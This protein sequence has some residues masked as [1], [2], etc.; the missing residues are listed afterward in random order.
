MHSVSLLSLYS[1]CLFATWPIP[2][3]FSLFFLIHFVCS[4]HPLLKKFYLIRQRK[5]VSM[6][7]Q[8]EAGYEE[9]SCMQSGS[10]R[11]RH[12]NWGFNRINARTEALFWRA[13]HPTQTLVSRFAWGILEKGFGWASGESGSRAGSPFSNSI[14]DVCRRTQI[15]IWFPIIYYTEKRGPGL[16]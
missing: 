11:Q 2:S 7:G 6:P 12:K 3:F 8:G 10:C 9:Q 16:A 13:L 4:L 14:P 5:G 15:I 1:Q